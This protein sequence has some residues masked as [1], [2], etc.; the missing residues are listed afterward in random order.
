MDIQV[1]FYKMDHY[2]EKQANIQMSSAKFLD[3]N[4][5]QMR[6]RPPASA[7]LSGAGVGSEKT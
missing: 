7:D 3:A 2:L 5:S 6:A 1:P 4:T